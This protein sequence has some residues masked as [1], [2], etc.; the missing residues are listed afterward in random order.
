MQMRNYL[1]PHRNRGHPCDGCGTY[2]LSSNWLELIED[3]KKEIVY[4]F[5]KREVQKK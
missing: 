5:Y 4:K 3:N 1:A 2:W